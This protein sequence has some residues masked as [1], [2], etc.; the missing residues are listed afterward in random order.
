MLRRILISI[1]LLF[2]CLIAGAQAHSAYS[3]YSIFG[4]GDISR[5]GT[6]YN[7][8]MGGVG[9]ASRN[10]R[11]INTLNP[12]AVTARDSLAFMADFCLAGDNKIF[13]EAAAKSASNLFNINS[14]VLSFPIYDHSAM[15]VGI[16]PYSS[17][18][19]EFS[20]DY[21]N[22][23]LIGYTNSVSY[24]AAGQGSIYKVFASA[25]VTLFKR[26]SLG[27]QF[28]YYFGSISKTYL[29]SFSDNSYVSI[30]NGTSLQATA[31]GAKLGLQYEQ[32]LG[33]KLKL[34]IGATAST[35]ANLRGFYEDSKYSVGSESKEVIYSQN[36]TLNAQNSSKIPS[37]LGVGLSLKYSNVWMIEFDYTRSDWT[38]SKLEN[39]SG[40][41]SG[42]CPFSTSV[43]QAFRLGMEY[44]PNAN[45][46]RYYFNRVTYRAGAYY[47]KEHYLYNGH[48][49]SSKG[50][51]FGATLP[52]YRWYNGL[53]IGLEIGQRGTLADNLIRERY[54]NFTIGVNIF[55]IW[56]QK[57]QY[58]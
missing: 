4:V 6:A 33:T 39:I 45:D 38:K 18:G 35:A 44:I 57:P 24:S 1:N 22:P 17:T 43:A 36:D 9:I 50:L 27:A 32:P 25:G 48:E 37:E 19:F 8:S 2:V 29:T 58:E 14:I 26:L 13:S 10:N 31:V 49:I 21:T 12:A 7:Q 47:K 40:Y 54:F 52:I 51:T 42:S 16:L 3:P 11:F 53:T 55:D 15:M 56:F 20:F 41:P 5:Q 34:G 30:S 23:Q 28:D 46:I